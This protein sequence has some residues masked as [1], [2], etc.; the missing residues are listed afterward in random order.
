MIKLIKL[1][2]KHSFWETEP[3]NNPLKRVHKEGIIEKIDIKKYK[4][5]EPTPLPEGFEW[6]T[7][8][9]AKDEDFDELSE[10]LN[11]HYVESDMK[12]FRLKQDR[13]M[14]QWAYTQPGFKKEYFIVIRNSKSRKIMANFMDLP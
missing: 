11:Y 8:D 4:A 3:I 10:F 9:P 12:D 2:G 7:L 13:E 1:C 6:D 14:L 5:S